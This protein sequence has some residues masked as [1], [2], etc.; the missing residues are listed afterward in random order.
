[1]STTLSATS[2][3]TNADLSSIVLDNSW[4]RDL[5]PETA[6]NLEKSRKTERLSKDDDNRSKR[7]VFNGHYVLVKP[8]GLTNPKLVLVSDDVAENLLKLTTEQVESNQ[9]LQFVSG[10]LVL[11]DGAAETWATPYALSIMGSRYTNNCPYGTGNGYGDGRAI[12]IAEFSGHELQ[13][14]GAGKTPFAR[15]AD[16]RAVLRSSI[17]EFLASEAMHSLGIETTRALSLVRSDNGDTV[18]R[19]WYSDDAVL[20]IPDIDDPRLAQYPEEERRQIIQ[21]LRASRKADPNMMISEP[22]AITCRVAKSFV[23]IGH[24]DLFSRRVVAQQQ[25]DPQQK[26]DT[27]DRAWKELEEIIWHACKREYKSEAYDPYIE[28]NNLEQ[29]AI[30]MLDL[31]AVR[32]ADM[33]SGWVRVGFAQGNFN[34]DNCLIGGRTMDY[35]PFGWM[36]EFTPLFAKW[37]GSGQHFGFL[38]QPSA[39]FVNYQV[40]VESVL[41]VIAVAQ[42]T[43][44]VTDI[45]M[46]DKLL[47]T[48]MTKAQVIFNQKVEGVFNLKMGLPEDADAGED[49]WEALQVLMADTRTDW[50]LFW[51][52]LTYVMK[53]MDD[54]DSTE[55]ESMLNKLEDG[56]QSSESSPFYEPL[57]SRQ[58]KDWTEWIKNWREILKATKRPSNEVYEQM[59]KSNPKF[60]L[61]EW[62]LVEAYSAAA[63]G[64][65]SIV[66]DLHDLCKNP[67]DEGT[68]EQIA[69]YY[70]RQPES[71]IAKGGTAFMS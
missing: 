41:P 33:V 13:L 54:L 59:Q 61:R 3:S 60:V 46:T 57:T 14:K 70:R 1:M 4:P 36:D 58:R 20:Q 21:Q 56:D 47:E 38:N 28:S 68:P 18:L 53:D 5:S 37:T 15:G 62:I 31:A 50:T 24:T 40:L 12:S 34:A 8:T 63:T 66:A 45:E 27:T 9:F 69:R 19:P 7:P 49:L 35:G 30:T 6:E 23:R 43:A 48:F 22:C 42:R 44:G 16:G 10:N 11:N 64:D 2:A 51:R 26:Y 17:R 55:Y 65:F 25:Q 67:Y 32:I 71:S 52:Q 29:A 39:G